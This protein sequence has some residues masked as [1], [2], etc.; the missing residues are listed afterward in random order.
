MAFGQIDPARL[1]GDALKRWYLRSPADL[2]EERQ[3]AASHAY[4]A[5][6]SQPDEDQPDSNP[7]ATSVQST[8]VPSDTDILG[9]V[10][11]RGVAPGR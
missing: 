10:P 6:F 7:R 11:G 3:Q 8:G 4:N 1:D 5:F 9:R 2:E